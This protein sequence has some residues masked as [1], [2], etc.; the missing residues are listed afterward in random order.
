MKQ[1][2]IDSGYSVDDYIPEED[3]GPYNIIGK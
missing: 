3:F 2:A 1:E